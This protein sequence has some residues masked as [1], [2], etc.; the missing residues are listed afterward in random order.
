V[1]VCVCVWGGGTRQGGVAA[2]ACSSSAALC[3]SRTGK[4]KAQAAGRGGA[5]AT[6]AS[7]DEDL[8]VTEGG[9][10]RGRGEQQASALQLC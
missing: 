5:P 3:K 8:Q 1:F 10:W 4:A 2:E 6:G 9:R 7:L